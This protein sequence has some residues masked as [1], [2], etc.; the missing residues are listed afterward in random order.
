LGDGDDLLRGELREPGR[1]VAERPVG[2]GRRAPVAPDRPADGG[3]PAG[4]GRL[5][6]VH[7]TLPG[8]AASLR[9]EGP[10]DPGGARPRE[11]GRGAE[12][13]AIQ[14]GVGPGPDAAGRPGLPR[15]GGVRG[16][17]A[18]AVRAAQRG[19]AGTAPGGA[20]AVGFPAATSARIVPPAAA[21][22][23][24]GQHDPRAGQHLLGGEPSD[25]RAGGGPAVRGAGR[26]VVRPAAGGVAAAP[27]GAGQAPHRVPP[28]DRLAGAQAGSVRGLSL[29]AGSV[30]VEPLPA[31]LRRA[32]GAAAG[33]GG[34]GVPG[35]LAPG[36]AAFGERRRGGVAE[37]AGGGSAAGRVGG[38]GGAEPE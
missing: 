7:A 23:G 38:G 37:A 34:E 18:S 29:S 33:A 5:G 35:G 19:A 3:D 30:P 6:V 10:G 9:P 4:D 21:A 26:G 20:G 2:V 16:V 24:L 1:G 31:G 36:G 13:P 12:P 32:A 28:R 27:A 8:V 17:P 11:R 15:T 25:R 22:G 14:A